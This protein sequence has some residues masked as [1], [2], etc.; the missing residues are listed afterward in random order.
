MASY[1]IDSQYL[2][3]LLLF[4][5]SVS[6]T[7]GPNNLML[8]ASGS[9]F[10]YV[11]T[12]PHI[13]GACLG[14]TLLIVAVGAGLGSVFVSFPSLQLVLKAAGSVY[15]LW[16]AWK[17]ATASTAAKAES[18]GKPLSTL[19]AFMFQWVNPK[20]WTM[21]IT[22]FSAFAV[23][24]RGMAWSLVIITVVFA[25]VV[26]PTSLFW[27]LLGDQVSQHLTSE[28]ARQWFNRSLGALTALSVVL[29]V[30]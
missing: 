19:Q 26:V 21:A 25:L 5:F 2:I 7:P 23:E 14:F 29:I 22:A 17:I 16:L 30:G 4:V 20:G 3:S 12:L 9:H 6:V 18:L 24:G 1:S 10:G 11:R 13:L 28:R 15:L 8:T 27:T